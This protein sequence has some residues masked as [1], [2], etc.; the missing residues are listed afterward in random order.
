MATPYAPTSPIAS[1]APSPASAPEVDVARRGRRPPR[2]SAPTASTSCSATAAPGESSVT[3]WRAP[4]SIGRRSSV[5]PASATRWPRA[6]TRTTRVRSQPALATMLRPGSTIS[7]AVSGR[8]GR[9][10]DANASGSPAK[11]PPR[12][13]RSAPVCSA[14]EASMR[15][16]LGRT[17]PASAMAEPMCAPTDSGG[18][19]SRP[20]AAGSSSSGDPELRIGR[21]GGEMRMRAGI[22]GGVDAQADPAGRRRPQQRRRARRA[23]RR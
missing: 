10:A 16:Q 18:R 17:A 1:S 3:G 7:R 15:R 22:E 6:C 12:S 4:Y 21:S 9:M 20:S 8:C 23:T 13:I 11:P 19:P 14:S 2:R 5:M